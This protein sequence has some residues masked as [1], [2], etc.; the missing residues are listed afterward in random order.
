MNREQRH[1]EK[2]SQLN[3]EIDRLR[4]KKDQM[5]KELESLRRELDQWRF[6][7]CFSFLPFLLLR[8]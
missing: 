1:F 8:P 3:I 6:G 2:Q 5:E 7:V 4:L